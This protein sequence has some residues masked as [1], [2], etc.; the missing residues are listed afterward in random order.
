MFIAEWIRCR[1]GQNGLNTSLSDT[2]QV[3]SLIFPPRWKQQRLL[4]RLPTT[5]SSSSSC[6]VVVIMIIKPHPFPPA[7]HSVDLDAACWPFALLQ[8]ELNDRSLPQLVRAE[9][10]QAKKKRVDPCLCIQAP[11]FIAECRNMSDSRTK[12]RK[13]WRSGPC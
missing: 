4:S 7:L 3:P 5:S 12:K 11:P 1:T 10:K 13:C 6:V 9:C 2:I 8:Q